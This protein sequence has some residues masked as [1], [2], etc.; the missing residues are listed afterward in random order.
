MTP[1]ADITRSYT[2]LG[3]AVSLMGQV[4]LY[5]ERS[6][7]QIGDL[8]LP[9]MVAGQLRIWKRGQH[10]VALA[11]WAW[12]DAATEKAVLR[13]D[14]VLSPE[15]W[16]CGDRP[17]VM[18]IVA[19]YGDGFAIARDLAR[20][21]FAGQVVHA[22]RRSPDGRAQRLSRFSCAPADKFVRSAA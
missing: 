8:L 10:P 11:S 5:A 22:V 16:T 14:Y 3:E 20:G 21:V 1:T 7:A 2:E 4:P 6:L 9:A 12:L 18:D 17:V 13:D 19:P 15:D